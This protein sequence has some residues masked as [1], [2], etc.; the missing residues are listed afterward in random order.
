MSGDE[1]LKARVL[2]LEQQIRTLEVRVREWQDTTRIALAQ[3]DYQVK[4]VAQPM[5]P[6]T[7]S[8]RLA[9]LLYGR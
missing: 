3:M 6:P 9:W 7:F 1:H 8:G 5:T 2:L 4:H